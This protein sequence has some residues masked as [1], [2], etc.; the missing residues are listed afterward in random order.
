MSID[1]LET[2]VTV[3]FPTLQGCRIMSGSTDT[4]LFVKFESF[5]IYE[6]EPL[7]GLI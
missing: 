5:I 2:V 7:I 4:S 1:Q 3:N 6:T